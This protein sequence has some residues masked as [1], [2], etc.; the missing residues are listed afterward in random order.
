MARAETFT[1]S[2][3][4]M[5]RACEIRPPGSPGHV[6][7]L[8]RMG[9]DMSKMAIAPLRAGVGGRGRRIT[10]PLAKPTCLRSRV[11]QDYAG[12]PIGT[13]WQRTVGGGGGRPWPLAPAAPPAQLSGPLKSVQM[14]GGADRAERGVRGVYVA[15]TPPRA[16]AA[17]GPFSAAR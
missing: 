13:S 15:A 16:N 11:P 5:D 10:T 9:T 3:R 4:C 7:I 12:L 1:G 2:P 17:D 8:S 6:G 14:Q